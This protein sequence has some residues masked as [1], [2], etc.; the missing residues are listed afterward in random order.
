MVGAVSERAAFR[1]AALCVA[2]FPLLV[3][4]PALLPGRVLSSADQLLDSYLFAQV[5]PARFEPANRLLSDPMQ[6]MIPWRRLVTEELRAGRLPFWN[7]YAYAGSPLLGNSQSAVFDPLS[8]PYLLTSRPEQATVWVALLR[9]WVAGFGAFFFARALRRSPAACAIAGLA[10][11]SGGFMV[12]WLLYPHTASAAWFPWS[13]L[14]AEHLARRRSTFVTVAFGLTLA[15]SV[16]GGHVEVAF[17]SALASCVYAVVRCVQLQGKGLKPLG[18]LLLTFLAAGGVTASVAA[19]HILPFL[20]ALGG[21]SAAAVRRGWWPA[22][23]WRAL[24]DWRSVIGLFDRFV[25]LVYPFL[26]GR[27]LAGEVALNQRFTN[28]C[29]HSGVYVSLLAMALAV[30]TV[31]RSARKS[32]ERVLLT[33]GVTAWLYH[34]WFSPILFFARA[35]PVLRLV[36]PTRAAFIPLLS[37]AVLAGFGFDALRGGA[38]KERFVRIP[39]FLSGLAATGAIGAVLLALWMRLGGLEAAGITVQD[40]SSAELGR[41]YANSFL[42]PWA[43]VAVAVAWLLSRDRSWHGRSFAATAAVAIVAADLWVFASGY[44]PSVPAQQVFPSTEALRAVQEAAGEGRLVVLDYG[45]PANVA[46]YYGISDLCG[47]DAINRR[48]LEVLARLAGAADREKAGEA[49]LAFERFDSWLFDVMAIRSVVTHRPLTGPWL[50]EVTAPPGVHIYRNRRARPYVFFPRAVL[51]VPDPVQAYHCLA[52]GGMDHGA[53]AVVE[54]PGTPMPVATVN[55]VRWARPEPGRIVIE[56][57]TNE[58]GTLVV[59]ES[60][61]A[62]W[63]ARVDGTAT[64]VHACDLSVM[65]LAVPAGSHVVELRYRPRTWWIAVV[66]TVAGAG[67]CMLFC[68]LGRRRT[69]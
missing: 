24:F 6:Q 8:L 9:C 11:G 65:A 54:A 59:A 50:E 19:V 1:Y 32:P 33:V 47:Y 36:F 52:G 27:P 31:A 14:A 48:R 39:R 38:E 67:V 30:I 20:E 35:I 61:D 15:A 4:G 68:L 62:G 63:Q 7:P 40:L 21:G 25:L 49:V 29:E 34:S 16:A 43:A 26:H 46:T 66:L 56:A 41:R 23:S 53:T 69:R 44:S 13:M 28:F 55:T 57:E 37:F 2:A 64:R 5:R 42:L 3:L 60:Y 51:S 45:M 58:P 18:G 10:F 12:V 17:L 22:L